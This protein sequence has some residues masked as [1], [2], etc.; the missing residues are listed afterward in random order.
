MVSAVAV[1]LDTGKVIESL[2]PD[3][4][5]IPASLTKLV[6]A[7]AALDTWPVDT[8]FDTHV[9]ATGEFKDGHITG[10]LYL[11]GG[12]DSTMDHG[13]LWA[14]AAQIRGA[15]ITAIDG[16]LLVVP[17]PFS[18]VPCETKDRC[19]A[20][21]KSD[22]AYNAPIT[23]MG[24][25]YG[26]WCIDARPTRPGKAAL[27]LS[28]AGIG[29]PIGVVGTVNTVPA[30]KPQTFWIERRTD[31][32]GDQI[33]ASGDLP[34][35][36]AQRIYRAM[37]N[38]ELGV[39][40]LLKQSLGALGVS[41]VG[42]TKVFTDPVPKDAFPVAYIEG[43]PLREQVVRMLRYSNNYIADVLTM[44]LAV[45]KRKDPPSTLADGAS[46]LSDYVSALPS[47]PSLSRTE[48]KPELYSGSGLTPENR[49]SAEELV[50]VLAHQYRNTDRF[51]GYY[52]GLVVPGDAP[53]RYLKN[54]DSDWRNRVALKT[55]TLTEPISAH[56][57][58]GYLR[59]KDGGWIAFATIVNGSERR[60][61]I[62]F[63]ESTEAMRDDIEDL[64]K[65]Y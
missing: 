42:E 39:G 14:L 56:G 17:A 28:C 21:T 6:T 20:L 16:R 34:M 38:P 53:F 45:R 32:N 22:T 35:N 2:N 43:M 3:K 40:L 13:E 62:A 31:E 19:D 8:S 9:S 18:V 41:V 7:S 46:V 49:I 12:G 1:D 64:L 65:K 29:L 15:G 60:K 59:K 33:Y 63:Y 4:R 61:R 48:G 44:N 36:A 25:D 47:V 52:G 58:S 57:F 11:I 50:R 5:V 55:G 23:A 27:L 30:G 10:D 54:G 37:S 24:I 26:T 51:P